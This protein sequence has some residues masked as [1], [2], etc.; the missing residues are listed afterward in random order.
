MPSTSLQSRINAFESLEHAAQPRGGPR[1]PVKLDNLLELDATNTISSASSASPPPPNIDKKTSLIDLRDWVF[2]DG[3]SVTPSPP[4]YRVFQPRKHA[5]SSTAPLINLDL[6]FQNA[7][8][9]PSLPPRKPSPTS[10][11]YPA[12]PPSPGLST[13]FTYP[14][15]VKKLDIPTPSGSKGGHAHASSISSFHSVSLSDTEIAQSPHRL[16]ANNDDTD[17]FSLGG[18]SFDDMSGTSYGSPT[19]LD[20]TLQAANQIPPK[21]PQRPSPPSPKSSKTAPPTVQLPTHP[22]RPLP[23]M[24]SSPFPRSSSTTAY[25]R[26]APPPPPSRSSASDVSSLFST[27][28][29]TSTSTNSARASKQSLMR[30]TPVPPAAQKRYEALFDANVVQCKRAARRRAEGKPIPPPKPALLSAATTRKSRHA[31]GWRG[32]SVDLIT[33]PDDLLITMDGDDD[34]VNEASIDMQAGPND[35]LDGCA[36]CLLWECSKLNRHKLSVIW[37]ECDTDGR[38]SLD[39]AAFVKGMWRIDEELRRAHT[40]PM[41]TSRT[42]SSTK[43]SSSQL[44]QPPPIPIARSKS[45]PILR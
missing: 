32:L 26:R 19:A 6:S 36:V 13:A 40:V 7:M 8:Q 42:S 4:P 14:P 37:N 12:V 1:P 24:A 39:R 34:A 9:A 35:R 18:D 29:I 27:T 38:G 10:L 31:A 3:S 21:L 25:T 23:Q 2:E 15:N 45:K 20:A 44:R 16:P 33:G 17:D 22:A 11:R 41:P 5:S 28:S 43:S 30:P